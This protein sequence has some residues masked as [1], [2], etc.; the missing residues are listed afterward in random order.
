M[1]SEKGDN[2]ALIE[3]LDNS[4]NYATFDYNNGKNDRLYAYSLIAFYNLTKANECYKLDEKKSFLE[5]A[6]NI[7]TLPQVL[8]DI[9]KSHII[10][11]AF[12]SLMNGQESWKH[13]E[14]QFKMIIEQDK[15]SFVGAMGNLNEKWNFYKYRY[16]IFNA[17]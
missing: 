16:G 3:L 13:A 9:G 14:D 8:A 1:Y 7:L 6:Q 11:S 2:D 10:G 4:L 15:N 12:A 5:S 17:K